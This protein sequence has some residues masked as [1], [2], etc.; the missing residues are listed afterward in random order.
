MAARERSPYRSEASSAMLWEGIVPLGTQ[1]EFSGTLK[2]LRD[3]TRPAV[4][5]GPPPLPQPPLSSLLLGPE[6]PQP[7]YFQAA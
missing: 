4:I 2:V 6:V 1:T 3:L 5:L 7:F